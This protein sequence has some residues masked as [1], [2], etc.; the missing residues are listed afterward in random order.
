MLVKA[1]RKYMTSHIL[2][3]L[4]DGPEMLAQWKSENVRIDLVTY[5]LTGVNIKKCDASFKKI[6]VCVCV[7]AIPIAV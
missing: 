5:Q 6:A 2:Q 7:E 1:F 3:S 4:C